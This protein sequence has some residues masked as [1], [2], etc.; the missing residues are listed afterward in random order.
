MIFCNSSPQTQRTQRE[1]KIF[2]SV[3]RTERKK[4]LMPSEHSNDWIVM[5]INK[6]NSK[7]IGAAL[8]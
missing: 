8:R 6:L 7:I 1:E 5:D 3:E 4:S 2:L